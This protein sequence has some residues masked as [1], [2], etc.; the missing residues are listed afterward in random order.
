M[1]SW[2]P[3]AS[4]AFIKKV[5]FQKIQMMKSITGEFMGL[6]AYDGDTKKEDFNH[7]L[8]Y[9]TRKNGQPKTSENYWNGSFYCYSWDFDDK[10]L[11]IT[12]SIDLKENTIVIA[13][14]KTKKQSKL[15]TRVFI[16]NKKY[17]ESIQGKKNGGSIDRDWLYYKLK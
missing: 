2:S 8:K 16:I 11:Y 7:L 10:L 15:N 17:L 13:P 14:K 12:S 6:V 9:F 4:L 5:S 1:G 3:S